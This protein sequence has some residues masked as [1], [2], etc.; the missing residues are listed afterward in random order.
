MKSNR[1]KFLFLCVFLVILA[2][3]LFYYIQSGKNVIQ[4][5]LLGKWVGM[6][7]TPSNEF[8]IYA[9]ISSDSNNNV[10]LKI[11]SPKQ[12]KYLLPVDSLKTAGDDVSFALTKYRASY[13]GKLITDSSK[14]VGK[15]NQSKFSSPL[16]FYRA[17]EIGR[18]DRPQ[19]PFKPYGYNS[20]SVY[21]F[22]P[23]SN[24]IS[25]TLTYPSGEDKTYP[26]VIL[27]NGLN[28]L[29]RDGTMYKHKPFLVIS[30]FLTKRGFAVLRV[31]DR[32]VTGSSSDI[33]NSSTADLA[34]DVI[35]GINYLKSQSII[36]INKIGLL[37]FNEGGII[38]SIAASKRKDVDFAILLSTP[39]VTGRKLL[40]TQTKELQKKADI[41]EEEIKRD[42]EINKKMFNIIET[43][44][45]TTD[46][47]TKLKKLYKKFRATLPQKDLSRRKYSA[48]IFQKKIKFMIA[49]WFKHF[50]MY[51]PQTAF[52]QIKCPVL[53]LFGENDVE[54][55]PKANLKSIVK[56]L[57][58]AGNKN[59]D[60]KIFKGLNHLFQKSDTGFPTEYSKIKE[61]FSVETLTYIY[62][63][64]NK[65]LENEKLKE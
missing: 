44:G 40:L 4:P 3:F 23:D 56:A 32:G 61:T 58:S 16:I 60:F 55:N 42:Y 51:N 28:K 59:V 27:I 43:A 34:S 24:K 5:A 10:S 18:I 62:N 9:D 52:E 14:I 39:G 29:D 15:W 19:Y 17:D 21:Y 26:A 36:D 25:G 30:D 50:L 38:A 64:I 47:I 8:L 45:D 33:N 49:P 1:I 53:I 35:A 54:L 22:D 57:E 37:G 6:L 7:K 41:S 20:D 46:A 31:D 48:K 12:K 11:S 2:Y 65:T 13:K 63:W